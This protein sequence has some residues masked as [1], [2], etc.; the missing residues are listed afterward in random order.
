[1][2]L[3]RVL[4]ESYS[5]VPA[6]EVSIVMPC[7]NE[8]ETL[9]ACIR[10]AKLAIARYHL[11]AE[12]IVAD[13]GSR[14][15]SVMIA[16]ALGARVV[17]ATQRGYGAAIRAGVE[18]AHG[19]YVI[20]GDADDSYDF[21][22]IGPFIERLRAGADLVM[23]NRF[24][25]G[26]KAGAMP[27]KHQYIGNPL[28]SA[29]GRIFFRTR[30]GDFYCGLRAMRKDAFD[31]LMLRTT[32]MEFALEMVVKT[33]LRRLRIAEVPTVLNKDGRS[34]PPH[35]RTFR[36]GWRGLRFMLLFSPRWLFLVPGMAMLIGGAA[37]SIALILSPIQLGP[38][39]LD[40]GTL[41]VSG[42]VCLIGY[43]VA[44]FGVFTKIFAVREGFHPEHRLLNRLYRVVTLEV[45][46]GA[47]GVLF[48]A[49]LSLL[50]VALLGW[51]AV[52]FG[53]L[54]P[55]TEMRELIPAVVSMAM[56]IQTVFSSFF[57]SILAIE[58]R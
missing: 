52:G 55:R 19:R 36:D 13:N 39:G 16:T 10:K 47:G 48:L 53:A 38:F 31:S 7:L 35:L 22:S 30:V 4:A 56:G 32:G 46:L 14:D 42:F 8:A 11:D 9:E 41:L 5:P 43:Q 27:W 24:K 54:D 1:M 57:L 26:I 34:R 44:L 50:V 25:G 17:N 58:S 33:A 12:I 37:A 23:G 40:Y 15:Q 2:A 28:L 45:G 6:I 29:I 3:D 18:A 21:G 49:G 51:R 20:I